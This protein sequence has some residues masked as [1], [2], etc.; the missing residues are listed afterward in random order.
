MSCSRIKVVYTACV[1]HK[2]LLGAVRWLD[3]P[4]GEL[5]DHPVGGSLATDGFVEQTPG[6]A[7]A[8]GHG[9]VVTPEL[10]WS[11]PPTEPHP[12]AF[13]ADGGKPNWFLLMSGLG[14]A[15]ALAGVVR[16]LSFAVRPVSEGGK[17]YTPHS[18]RQVPE[19]K[20]RYEAALFRHLNDIATGETHDKES[21][22][23]HWYHVATNALF[24]AELHNAEEKV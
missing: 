24:L 22:E 12:Q 19:A 1:K 5:F 13:K 7:W 10:D 14:C 2:G 9:S 21:K 18:W 15:K 11:A 20:E 3:M 4:T 23:S 16:V 8:N 17:G 6:G